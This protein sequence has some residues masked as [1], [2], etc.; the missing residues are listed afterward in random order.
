MDPAIVEG[1]DPMVVRW[2]V[3][4]QTPVDPADE[5]RVRAERL[6]ERSAVLG[7][8]EVDPD[9][10]GHRVALGYGAISG[11]WRIDLRAR[12]AVVQ[13]ARLAS[14]SMART[15][16]R[17]VEHLVSIGCVDVTVELLDLDDE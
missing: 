14:N 8:P 15:L 6:S 2:F 3:D 11:E 9:L 13:I 7:G 17:L 1:I 16:P 5:E 12:P 4:G 10:S